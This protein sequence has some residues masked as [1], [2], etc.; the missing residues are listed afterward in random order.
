[1]RQAS[2][3]RSGF[4]ETELYGGRNGIIEIFKERKREPGNFY[5]A[6][7]HAVSTQHVEVGWPH[8]LLPSLGRPSLRVQ[9]D[10]EDGGLSG[11]V[12]CRPEASKAADGERLVRVGYCSVSVSGDFLNTR[13][14]TGAAN[15]KGSGFCNRMSGSD[16]LVNLRGLLCDTDVSVRDQPRGGLD[17]PSSRE[18]PWVWGT[19]AA[20]S[21]SHCLDSCAFLDPCFILR[22][23]GLWGVVSLVRASDT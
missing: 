8:A 10:A 7:L 4:P 21:V 12:V 18:A 3:G 13:Q 22:H 19:A 1:M 11:C 14:G 6:T 5:P 17:M 23:A 9:G 16:R 20:P 2:G 15:T